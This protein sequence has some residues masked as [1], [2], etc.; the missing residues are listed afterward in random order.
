MEI[1]PRSDQRPALVYYTDDGSAHV[2]DQI[3]DEWFKARI[4]RPEASFCKE[5]GSRDVAILR[6]LITLVQEWLDDPG[7]PRETR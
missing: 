7:D 1:R 2:I 3:A 5:F 4:E 6:G